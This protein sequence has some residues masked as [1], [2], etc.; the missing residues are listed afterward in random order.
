M[1]L[2][3]G[4]FCL[5][6]LGAATSARAQPGPINRPPGALPP[7]YSP[8]LN[9]NRPGDPGIN[10]YGL[11]RPQFFAE[12]AYRSLQAQV[13]QIQRE[14]FELGTAREARVLPPTGYP[15]RFMDYGGYFPG[16]ARQGPQ[17]QPQSRLAGQQRPTPSVPPIR[18]TSGR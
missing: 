9:L 1:I 14:T 12:N 2:R 10:Y 7:V 4:V 16:G 18:G 8:Y 5:L 3:V 6:A 17:V 13:N 11:V 15:A